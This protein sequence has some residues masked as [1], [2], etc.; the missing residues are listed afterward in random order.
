VRAAVWLGCLPA[1][2]A[3]GGAG[4]RDFRSRADDV[5]AAAV[6]QLKPLDRRLVEIFDDLKAD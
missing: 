3:H 4:Q 2:S 6:R 5:C 1:A